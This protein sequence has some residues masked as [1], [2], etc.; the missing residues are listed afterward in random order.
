MPS[1]N[2]H[3]PRENKF[4]LVNS[5][6]SWPCCYL[7]CRYLHFRMSPFFCSRNNWS[8]WGTTFLGFESVGG[9]CHY[10]NSTIFF[11]SRNVS[12]NKAHLS[13][14]HTPKLEF[15]YPDSSFQGTWFRLYLLPFFMPAMLLQTTSQHYMWVSLG[16]VG[17][18]TFCLYKRTPHLSSHPKELCLL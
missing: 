16:C 2:L 17:E 1:S 13:C 8:R 12:S 11:P 10:W 9:G 5:R 15:S 18:K 3:L 7:G 14:Q 4:S 6:W